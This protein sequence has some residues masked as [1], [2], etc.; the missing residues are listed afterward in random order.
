MPIQ[1]VRPS[2][3]PEAVSFLAG[4]PGSRVLAGGTDLLVKWKNGML[5]GLTHLV[6]VGAL[7]L[8]QIRQDSGKIIIG[9]SC[10]MTQ[11]A[12]H[13]LITENFPTLAQAALT[14]G[15]FQIRNQA[16]IGGNVANASPAGDTI[17]ALM[18]VEATVVL[19]S[20]KGSRKV[21]LAEF[22][23]GPGKTIM[24][25]GDFIEFF[26]MP[27]R[28]TRG[29]FLKL[30]ERLAHAISKISLALT[31]WDIKGGRRAFRITLGAVAPTVIHSRRAE[32]LLESSL[33]DLTEDLISKACLLVSE[34]ATPIDD[35][36]ST[37]NYRK[38]MAGV[39]LRQALQQL[40]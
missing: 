37:R 17:P 12:T 6:D 40:K 19:A 32:T 10:I 2:S 16:T 24:K 29:V 26:E 7:G 23:T 18:S 1:C 30:G 22:F 20:D 31:T 5:P 36:R 8:D 33:G 25:A 38:K 39:L 34:D 15:A 21:P 14:V 11:V 4:N 3:L 27:Q 35:I 13:P 28:T 9:S